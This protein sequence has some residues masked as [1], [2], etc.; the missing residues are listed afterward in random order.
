ME[1]RE[2]KTPGDYI[3]EEMQTRNWTQHDLANILGRPLPSVN[4]IILGKRGIMPEMAVALGQAFGTGAEIWLQREG[5]YRLSLVKDQTD[6]V[7]K[8][9]KL[10]NSAPI[11]EIQKR[12]WIANTEDTE[13]IERELCRF[14]GVQSIDDE[15][16]IV[17]DFRRSSDGDNLSPSQKAWYFRARQI[18]GA[19]R[20]SPFHD[21]RLSQCE[22]ELVRLAS[23]PQEA[24]K[25]PK[26]L[27]SYGIRFVIVEPL[28]GSKVDGAAFWLN[29]SSPVIALSLRFDR[30]DGFWFNLGHEWSHIKHKDALSIDSNLVGQDH[31]PTAAKIPVEQRAD[32]DAAAMLVSPSQMQSFIYRMAPLYSKDRI[33]QFANR[34]KIHPGIIVGQLQYRG[35]I[36]FHAN[37]EMLVKIR[38]AII[39]SAVTD[40]WGE[41]INPRVFS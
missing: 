39:P 3:R 30:I 32:L 2:V 20:V 35:E 9:A 10:F 7:G 5:T 26:L 25:I 36:G 18:A 27:S 37:R 8:R 11:K 31:T 28:P 24:R 33:N 21:G 22:K 38:E 4:E 12:G 41:S 17:A 6:V 15:P 1:N 29:G 16:T 23:F 14:Y 34:I 19:L 40:G 13:E